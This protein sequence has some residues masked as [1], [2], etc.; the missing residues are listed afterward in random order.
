MKPLAA[1][2]TFTYYLEQSFLLIIALNRFLLLCTTLC[3]V[4]E[5][6][7][8]S[9]TVSFLEKDMTLSNSP[10]WDSL[11]KIFLITHHGHRS[12]FKLFSD[13]MVPM[14]PIFSFWLIFHARLQFLENS[15]RCCLGL[16]VFAHVS[17]FIFGL[18]QDIHAKNFN[19]HF[20]MWILWRGWKYLCY[21]W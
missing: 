6:Y 2:N 21:C 9:V 7:L 8:K 5:Y 13:F 20:W 17:T 19:F 18:F 14:V 3:I 10:R 4:K 15:S 11:L 16:R 12:V 1:I